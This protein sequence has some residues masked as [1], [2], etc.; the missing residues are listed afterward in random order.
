MKQSKDKTNNSREFYYFHLGVLI[1]L[2]VVCLYKFHIE[3]LIFTM[4]NMSVVIA[5]KYRNTSVAIAAIKEYV[6]IV[7]VI[8]LLLQFF[9]NAK[10]WLCGFME[11]LILCFCGYLSYR[12]NGPDL[13]HEDQPKTIY[14]EKNGYYSILITFT[15]CL[16][17]V[18]YHPYLLY[19]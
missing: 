9:V 11:I 14:D 5:N 18:A 6:G 10:W 1:I 19:N 2:L 16:L 13:L 4:I 7:D 12:E 3:M 17:I 8:Y 15:W